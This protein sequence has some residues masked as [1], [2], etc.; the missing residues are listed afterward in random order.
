M[1]VLKRCRFGED[2][3]FVS[4]SSG[5]TQSV[6]ASRVAGACASPGERTRL[7]KYDTT[8][9]MTTG[10]KKISIEICRTDWSKKIDGIPD[11]STVAG[12]CFAHYGTLRGMPGG[13]LYRVDLPV[14]GLSLK[15]K[16]SNV[17]N[18]ESSSETTLTL[19]CLS[20]PSWF[21]KP[22]ATFGP[23][24]KKAGSFV[25][26]E[27]LAA[28]QND[29]EIEF[30]SV[31]TKM[32]FLQSVGLSSG[33]GGIPAGA[34]NGDGNSAKVSA[35]TQPSLLGCTVVFSGLNPSQEHELK[36]VIESLGGRVTSAVSGKT[37]HLVRGPQAGATKLAKAENLN[38]A[39][40]A[41]I[42]ILTFEEFKETVSKCKQN[43][44][45]DA[46]VSEP[47]QKKQKTAES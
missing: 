19:E 43:E 41:G 36:Q 47:T 6:A 4:G 46:C 9:K 42:K 40:N 32:A 26:I 44:L 22:D 23:F 13:N 38:K 14:A 29:L 1:V 8:L 39:K 24:G 33:G 31:G 3:D 17:Q 7:G 18:E 25:A 12:R 37:S 20:N 45:S 35:S 15:A 21:E 5:P 11:T 27:S 10:A 2:A 34:D 30:E 16:D 28:V